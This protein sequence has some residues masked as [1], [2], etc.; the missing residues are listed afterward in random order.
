MSNEKNEAE[1][2]TLLIIININVI[3][4]ENKNYIKD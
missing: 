2:L 3:F 1:T 4:M